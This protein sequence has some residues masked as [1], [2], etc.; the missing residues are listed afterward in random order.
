MGAM[1]P[2]ERTLESFCILTVEP[3]DLCRS[4]HDRMPLILEE[5]SFSGW[6]DPKTPPDLVATMLR[7]YAA[8]EMECYPVSRIVNNSRNEMPTCVERI[9]EGSIP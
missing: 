8:T 3:N 9:A 6:L 2:G 7:P 1:A 4:V 5:K